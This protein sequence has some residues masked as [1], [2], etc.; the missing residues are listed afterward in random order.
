LS[1]GRRKRFDAIR[2]RCRQLQGSLAAARTGEHGF[3]DLFDDQQTES[4]NK[5]LWVFLRTLTYE[6][7]LDALCAS[8]SRK[9]IEEALHRTGNELAAATDEPLR[10]ALSESIE[11]LK[12]RLENLRRAQENLRNLHARLSRIENSILLVQEQA[13]TRRDPAFVEAEVKAATV[14]LDSVEEVLRGLDLPPIETTTGPPPE[15]L[16]REAVK[17][18]Q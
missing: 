14:G 8:V 12:K 10:A 6:Q 2:E 11:V 5:L 18:A 15:L 13:L 1:A 16:R 7:M 3:D 9:E 4:V 17:Q